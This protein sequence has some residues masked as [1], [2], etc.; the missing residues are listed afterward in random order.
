[1]LQLYVDAPFSNWGGTVENL[2]HFTYVPSTVAQIELIVQFAKKR[3]LSVRCSGFSKST[4]ENTRLHG[5]F[6][7]I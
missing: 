4:L 1:M 7:Q 6:K 2:P 3:D 5:A